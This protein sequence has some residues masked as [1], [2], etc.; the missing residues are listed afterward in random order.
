[1]DQPPEIATVDASLRLGGGLE[2]AERDHVMA[3]WG[4]LDARLRSFPAGTVELQLTVK[5]R[6]TP[7]QRTTLEAWIAGQPRL[8]ATSSRTTLDQALV[9]VR[10][11][12]IR[13]LTDAKTRTEP[14]NRRHYRTTSAD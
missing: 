5:E 6:D 1:M 10:D 14:R 9:E 3:C 4:S 12:M 2:P 13:Q 11:D 7:S 8:V